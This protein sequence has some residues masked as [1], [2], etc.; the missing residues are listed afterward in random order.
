[1]MS[2]PSPFYPEITNTVPRRLLFAALALALCAPACSKSAYYQSYVPSAADVSGIERVAVAEFDGLE[3]SGRIVALK[4]AEGIVDAGHFRLLERTELDRILQERDFN[5]SGVVD[6]S[7]VSDLKL[8]GV[9]GLIFGIVDAYSVD[10]QTGVERI[11]KEVATGR[12]REVQRKNDEGEVET[13]REEIMETVMVDRGYILRKGTIAVTFR[14]ANINTGEIVA[15]KTET[16][17]FAKRAWRDEASSLPTKD[18]ILEE[19]S[20]DVAL[21]FLRQIHPRWVSRRVTF[22][23]NDAPSTE[24][25]ISYAQSG[26]WDRAYTTLERAI[27]EVPGDATAHY[28]FAVVADVLGRYEIATLSIERAIELNPQKKYMRYLS[29]LQQRARS[30]ADDSEERVSAD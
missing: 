12:Y 29:S 10:S 15:L 7:T 30:S 24:V 16:A 25:G 22:E 17:H 23:E 6:P 1:M 13:V 8:L 14:M 27:R 9:D 20:R 19:M 26:L 28:N 3:R 2:H 4:L 5:Q 18:M 11:E 21:R